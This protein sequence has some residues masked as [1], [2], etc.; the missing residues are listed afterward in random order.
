MQPKDKKPEEVEQ[1]EQEKRQEQEKQQ[2]QE[3]EPDQPKK[4]NVIIL[5]DE[6]YD[7]P[8]NLMTQEDNELEEPEESEEPEEEEEGKAETEQEKKGKGKQ[9]ATKKTTS[10]LKKKRKNKSRK[11]DQWPVLHIPQMKK[12]DTV[13]L[14]YPDELKNYQIVKAE[15]GLD[16]VGAILDGKSNIAILK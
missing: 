4:R 1:Q 7:I 10:T 15:A 8:E 14:K 2:E 16:A 6:E 11:K 9:E 3:K 13:V 12:G 5:S